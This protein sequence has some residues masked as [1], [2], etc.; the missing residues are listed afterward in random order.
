MKCDN[1]DSPFK[2]LKETL[3]PPVDEYEATGRLHAMLWLPGEQV[4]DFLAALYKQAKRASSQH[5]A[6][7]REMQLR[8]LG[9]KVTWALVN[10]RRAPTKPRSCRQD[11]D[12][13]ELIRR[14]EQLE[15]IAGEV[16][17][18]NRARAKE[19][20]DRKSHSRPTMAGDWVMVRHETRKD[21]LDLHFEAPF[22]VIQRKGPNVEVICPKFQE[23]NR[24][25][26][27]GVSLGGTER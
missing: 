15:A 6:P 20:Y 8:V 10:T 26:R 2:L 21:A 13:E 17:A 23:G 5:T 25:I 4:E 22:R 27:I 11:P 24:C 16:N 3:D 12:L 9:G 7:H 18:R 14:R 19:F 1:L